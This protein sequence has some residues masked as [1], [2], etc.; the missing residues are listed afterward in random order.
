MR[1]A[2]TT[3]PSIVSR[4]GDACRRPH[5]WR[6]AVA[7]AGT[8]ISLTILVASC[9]KGGAAGRMGA[10]GAA[11][12]MV[13][14]V[15]QKAMPIQL[16]AIGNV[17]T[18]STVGIRSQVGGVLDTVHF[19]QGDDV[20]KGQLLFTID[21]RPFVAMVQQAEANLAR[22]RALLAKARSDV[23]RYSMLVGEDYV[24]K[25]QFD[26][27]T[28]QAASLAATVQADEAAVETA[29][30]Q[31]GYCEIRSPIAGRTGNLLIYAGNLIK[32]NDTTN[33]IVINQMDPIE[34]SFSVP[35]QYLPE[36]RERQKRGD[37]RVQAVTRG[38]RSATIDGELTFID[39]TVDTQTGTITLRG[40]FS[41]KD[42]ALWPGQFV[43]VLVT[44]G[45]Q[46]DAVVVPS[47]AVTPGQTG[48]YVFV[49]KP[50][51]TVESV[52]VTVDRQMGE[53]IVIAKGLK[54]GQTVV[55]DG[56][57]RLSPG[58]KVEV[59]SPGSAS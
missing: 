32:A 51:S 57:L 55:T 19:K 5:H 30:L 48:T 50:D 58:A 49:V 41:N 47:K 14:T 7:A 6:R 18:V 29:K 17:V 8:V 53:E 28:A 45:Q 24:T 34:V 54:P 37:L 1:T 9:S 38:K 40:T 4:T 43:D 21:R 13:A 22:D 16:H 15:I 12:V 35:E 44:L 10:M 11:P 27:T 36:I 20:A 26:Q 31:L 3:D 56:Q 46:P 52:P 23:K 39:N 2:P 59:K 33:L 25:E 42:R